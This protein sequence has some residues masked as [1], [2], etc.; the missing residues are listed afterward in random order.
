MPREIVEDRYYPVLDQGWIRLVDVMGDDQAITEAARTSYSKSKKSSDRDLLRY[1]FRHRHTSPFEMVELKF[2]CKM[3]IFVARQW[4]R[5]R[6]ASLNEMSGRYVEMPQEFYLPP[7]E[8]VKLQSRD[9]KQGRAEALSPEE[10]QQW[11]DSLEAQRAGVSAQYQQALK[12]GV[13]KEL[14]RIDLPLST[15]TQWYWKIDLHN[16]LHF[17]S[18]RYDPHAQWEIRAYAEVMLG[19]L[20][21]VVPQAVEAW[22]DYRHCARSFSRLDLTLLDHFWK[23]GKSPT[24]ELAKQIGMT[25]R[26]WEEF[27]AKT[28]GV[29]E[30]PAITLPEPIPCPS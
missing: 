9:N 1:L 30:V 20:K 29:P 16:L 19:I 7:V 18:L 21:E 17:L 24:L 8:Q 12:D 10:A 13:A 27:Q 11:L 28:S 23:S 6:T 22:V 25:G 15:Y 4:V 14:A 3:P 26:E 2:H 5:H